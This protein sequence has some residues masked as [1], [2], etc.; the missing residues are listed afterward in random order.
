VGGPEDGKSKES[1]EL[2]EKVREDV[3][4]VNVIHHGYVEQEGL[5]EL[6]LG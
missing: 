3:W 2:I 4:L 6:L 1:E 5:W